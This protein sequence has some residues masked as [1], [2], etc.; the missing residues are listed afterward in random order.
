MKYFDFTGFYDIF[1]VEKCIIRKKSL[2][3]QGEEK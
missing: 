3:N 1:M 2:E